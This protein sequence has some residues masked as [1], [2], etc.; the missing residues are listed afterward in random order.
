MII[1]CKECGKEISDKAEKCIHCG[2]PLK[3]SLKS[4]N[5][6]EFVGIKVFLGII[7]IFLSASFKNYCVEIAT[8]Q[9]INII[10]AGGVAF[11]LMLIGGIFMVCTCKNTNYI[12]SLVSAAIMFLC[13]FVIPYSTIYTVFALTISI[14]WLLLSFN[15]KK[16]MQ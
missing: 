5:K 11:I 10:D 2:F 8:Q 13:R 15:H 7:T 4:K 16:Q 1:K 14:I 9:N 12:F 3:Y 6:A